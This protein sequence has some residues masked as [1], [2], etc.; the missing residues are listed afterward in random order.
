MA[1][2]D[3]EPLATH[4]A[5]SNGVFTMTSASGS[6]VFEGNDGL[7]VAGGIWVGPTIIP[8]GAHVLHVLGR[9]G[10]FTVDVTYDLTSG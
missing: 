8:A 4:E 6:P 7:A 1:T 2:L 3:G 5:T 9:S 10:G